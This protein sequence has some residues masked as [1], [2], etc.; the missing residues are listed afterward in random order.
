VK[1]YSV[2]EGKAARRRI[3]KAATAVYAPYSRNPDA[4]AL[5]T[6]LKDRVNESV[7]HPAPKEPFKRFK[8]FEQLEPFSG[9]RQKE[10]M[11]IQFV[12]T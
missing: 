4:K 10:D 2:R 1:E 7:P 9:R 12:V 3:K 11:R 5:T 6:V 8:L